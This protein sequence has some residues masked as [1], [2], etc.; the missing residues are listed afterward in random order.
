MPGWFLNRRW[1]TGPAILI[2]AAGLTGLDRIVDG[3]TAARSDL[4]L[5]F[6][7]RVLVLGAVWVI[8]W[9]V[10]RV[11]LIDQKTGA[12]RHEMARVSDAAHDWRL[13]SRR[14]LEGLSEAIGVQFAIGV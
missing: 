9:L 2:L 7:D 13:R 5:D 4:A 14:L 12:L 10:L 3:Q 8:V 11:D 6:L 1:V